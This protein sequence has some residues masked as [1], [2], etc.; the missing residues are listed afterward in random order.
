MID[1]L[2]LIPIRS[3]TKRPLL[4]NWNL[5]ENCVIDY[6]DYFNLT[7]H[8]LAIAH[9]YCEPPTCCLDIDNACTSLPFLK[10]LGFDPEAAETTTYR[11]GRPNSVK[12]MF[13]L[14][15]ALET[16]QEVAFG[17]V[18]HELRCSN[19]NG[20]TAADVIPPSLHPSGTVY[21]YDNGLD[22]TAIKPLPEVLLQYWRERLTDKKAAKQAATLTSNPRYVMDSPRE[23][24]LIRKKLDY[25][26]SDCDRET[27]LK[28]VFSILATGLSDAVAIAEDWSCASS[29]FNRRDFDAAVSSYK[30]NGGIGIGTLHYYAAQGG[31]RD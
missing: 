31:Y 16:Y 8:D 20:T 7:G 27:W 29:K 25:I 9:A 2:A 6:K 22:L 18:I 13:L 30:P 3:G 11:S 12:L 10:A 23:V 5:R 28:V 19:A 26:S 14:D 17:S 21:A 1:S 15:E 4:P 24:A